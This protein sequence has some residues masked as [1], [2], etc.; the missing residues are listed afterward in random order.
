[1]QYNKSPGSPR[2]FFWPRVEA[3]V[4]VEV[5]V[6]VEIKIEIKVWVRLLTAKVSSLSFQLLYPLHELV[7][8]R[9]CLG[10]GER[11]F[12]VLFRLFVV[13]ICVKIAQKGK[14][15]LVVDQLEFFRFSDRFT[16]TTRL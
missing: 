7:L 10:K 15:E 4:E 11:L 8:V 16:F 9:V 12:E 3:E 1:M 2:G 5:E 6:E 14:I 13:D